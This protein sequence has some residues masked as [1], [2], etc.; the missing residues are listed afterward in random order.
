M[1]NRSTPEPNSP[2]RV[3]IVEDHA[4]IRELVLDFLAEMPGFQVVGSSDQTAPALAAATAGQIDLLILDLMLPG[5]GGVKALEAFTALPLRPRILVFSAVASLQTVERCLRLGVSAYVEKSAPLSHLQ[6]ALLRVRAGGV[7]LT[8]GVNEI[9]RQLVMRGNAAQR[10]PLLDER[11]LELVRLIC[12]DV[13]I[14]SAAAALGVS[15]PYVYRMRQN[16]LQEFG[17][18]SDQE[19]AIAALTMG[20]L[21]LPHP[22]GNRPEPAAGPNPPN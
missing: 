3:W 5:V 14:K 12:R 4:A 13:T 16:I 11:T 17:V 15:E 2:C 18:N 9:L 19:L 21:E 6:Q 22:S 1:E 10:Q 7:Y 20:L 8:D